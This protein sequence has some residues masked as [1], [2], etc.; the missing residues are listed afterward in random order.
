VRA[1]PVSVASWSSCTPYMS[2][3][4]ISAPE[5]LTASPRSPPGS[6]GERN[7]PPPCVSSRPEGIVIVTRKRV[8]D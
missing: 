3:A 4:K 7:R 1:S 6:A 5:S 8:G 2:A